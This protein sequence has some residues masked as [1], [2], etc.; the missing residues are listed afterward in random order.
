MPT[1]YMYTYMYMYIT[2]G[3]HWNELQKEVSV[4]C[5]K[6]TELSRSLQRIETYK[7]K[8]GLSGNYE[9]SQS[10]KQKMVNYM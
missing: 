4:F 9:T 8:V 2:G 3:K 7:T 10:I 6:G 5:S 1:L